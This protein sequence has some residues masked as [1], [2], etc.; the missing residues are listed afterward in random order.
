MAM[1]SRLNRKE[2]ADQWWR[3]C[4][5]YWIINDDG[6]RVKFYPNDAQERLY[7][8]LWYLNLVL[9]ARQQ[10]FSTYVL[11]KKFAKAILFSGT[12]LRLVPHDP[13]A[14][15]EF[16]S[17]LDVMCQALPP[18]LKPDTKYYSKE[19]IVFRDAAKGKRDGEKALDQTPDQIAFQ[20]LLRGVHF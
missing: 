12:N 7:R 1:D 5:L 17:R 18:H 14:E 6:E 2:W 15:E 4:N 11:A 3:L 13:D 19:E 9:K 8:N 20:Q 16:W 10:G